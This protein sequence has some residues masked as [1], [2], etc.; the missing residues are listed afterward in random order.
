MP[1]SLRQPKSLAY[2]A[3][4]L[5]AE[6]ASLLHVACEGIAKMIAAALGVVRSRVDRMNAGEDANY[7]E[8]LARLLDRIE[9]EEGTERIKPLLR[10]LAARYGFAL[11]ALAAA[12]A[13]GEE[14]ERSIATAVSATSAAL[15]QTILAAIDGIDETERPEVSRALRVGIETLTDTLNRV[16][17]SATADP[18]KSAVLHFGHQA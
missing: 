14:I 18:K 1:N 11:G 13:T 17:G 5:R 16:E 3:N 12:P 2:C 7:L 15:S 4:P 10:W 6:T 8:L 9:K